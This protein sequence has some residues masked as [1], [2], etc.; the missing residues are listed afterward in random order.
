MRASFALLILACSD[1]P[2]TESRTSEPPGT[3][4][5]TTGRPALV[6]VTSSAA[7]D[8]SSAWRTKLPTVDVNG[9]PGV[10]ITESA[11]GYFTPSLEEVREFE[12]GVERGVRSRDVVDGWERA[13]QDAFTRVFLDYPRQYVG[14]EQETR[15]LL[16]VLFMSKT[17]PGWVPVRWTTFYEEWRRPDICA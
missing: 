17:L 13:E 7:L 6:H 11:E 5:D 2:L 8:F 4:A 10:I 9:V 1:G 12:A 3:A 16:E 14:V 15:S